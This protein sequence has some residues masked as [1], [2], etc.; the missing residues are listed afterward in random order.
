VDLCEV[1]PSDYYICLWKLD[2]YYYYYFK[3]NYSN[4]ST[5][6]GFDFNS[7]Y[8]AINVFPFFAWRQNPSYVVK[9][10]MPFVLSGNSN[11]SNRHINAV[12]K[13]LGRC[14]KRRRSLVWKF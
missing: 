1:Y 8:S 3:I 9:C 6:T 13:E 14:Y 7:L 5:I 12:I 2:Y 10:V 11:F 4:A